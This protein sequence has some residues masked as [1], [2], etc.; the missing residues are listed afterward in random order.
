MRSLIAISLF[1]LMLTASGF[2]TAAPLNVVLI[3]TDDQ[4]YADLGCHGN[5]HIRTPNIDKMYEE[6]LRL[7]QY[8]NAP[9]CAPTRASLMTG[10]YNY[11]TGVVDTY[12]GRAMMHADETTLAEV[13]RDEGY[14]TGIFGKWHL[15]DNYPLRA[16]DQG[17]EESLVHMGGGISQP[18]NPI[19][20][21]YFDPVVMHNGHPVQKEGYC[22]DIFADATIDFIEK[23]QDK[24]FFAYL[25]T[26]APHTPLIVD[27]KYVQHYRDM[28]IP[29]DTAKIYGMDENI[30]ENVGKVLNK[31]D[32]LGLAENTLVI[33]M[34][35]NGPHVPRDEPRYDAGMRGRKGQVY[36]GGIRV[37]CIM[38]LPG[39]LTENTDLALPAAHIDLFPT[40][41]AA[42]GVEAAAG[43]GIDGVNLWPTLTGE[44]AASDALSNRAL[45][46]QWHRGD[47][48]QAFKSAAVRVGPYKLV[49]DDEL[50]DLRVDPAEQSNVAADHPTELKHM[51][52]AYDDWYDS[53]REERDF[54]FPRIAIGT[55]H[56]NPV[57]LTPQDWYGEI[58]W[59]TGKDNHWE[60]DIAKRGDYQLRIHFQQPVAQVELTLRFGEDERAL[61]LTPQRHSA[62]IETPFDMQP[63]PAQLAFKIT[64]KMEKDNGV[65]FVEVRRV[66]GKTTWD[67]ALFLPGD[68]VQEDKS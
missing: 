52:S 32:E 5:P 28:G 22:T 36:E 29:E 64:S 8:Y 35:D 45:F 17:F 6:S 34:T 31:I 21:G 42:C 47:R 39:T 60:V 10:R 15:G 19:D 63:G 1:L 25:S 26:N 33:Y 57:V 24:P 40:L 3:L 53:V 38:R 54:A 7:T 9:V 2:A 56:E 23:N 20:N 30:D 61:T 59:P 55:K 67:T 66:K 51:K 18:S 44:M 13:L 41:L 11:R 43:K 4:G 27:E 50:Y 37:P 68:D 65:R 46:F 62:T 14:K 16:M 12:M 49:S 58:G 48:P